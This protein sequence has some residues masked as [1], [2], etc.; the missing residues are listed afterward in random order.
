MNTKTT[1]TALSILICLIVSSGIVSS[2]FN[3]VNFIRAE[4]PSDG[5]FNTP[6]RFR[7]TDTER[8]ARAVALAKNFGGVVRIPPRPAGEENRDY[9]LIDSAILLGEG[10]TLYLDN[11]RIKLSDSCR[12]NFIRSAN[13]GLG[14]ETVEPIHNIHIIGIGHPVLEGADHPRATG[15]AGKQLGKQTYGTDAGKEDQSQYGDWRNIGILLAKVDGFT[16]S[17]ITIRQAHCWSVSLERC[18]Y[19]KIRDLNFDSTETR[20]IDGS[21]VKV[22]NVDGL[23]LRKGCHDITIENLYGH[24]GD[25]LL[26]ITLLGGEHKGGQF[27]ATEVADST[28]DMSGDAYN[29]TARN[30]V[31]YAAGG[32]N[33]VRFLNNG[34][35]K[36]HHIVL[37]TVIDTSP[38][39]CVD[40]ATVRIG[41]TGYGGPAP[42]GDTSGL[43]ITNV[44]T[45]SAE[46]IAIHGTLTDSIIANVINYNP[47]VS[48]VLFPGG[49]ETIR[50]VQVINFIN[51]RSVS[52]D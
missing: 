51:A 49:E 48:G 32:H 13:C 19:G 39:G 15:D 30:I 40:K 46:G 27:R 2:G 26:A 37:E 11:C 4:E 8:I 43:I 14:I 45:K 36:L 29:I 33:I 7:G 28:P 20:V 52:S 34:G 10:T 25:D 38:A 9:W 47:N 16:L 31:G 3:H 5:W 17:G 24:G 21:E 18:C 41:D 1:F 22:L 42:L 23:D 44:Q 35:R 6:E 12:D 50:N